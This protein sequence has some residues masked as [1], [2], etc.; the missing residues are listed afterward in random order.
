[1]E[2]SREMGLEH[3]LMVVERFLGFWKAW[4]LK[5]ATETWV[6]GNRSFLHKK[7]LVVKPFGSTGEGRI[8]EKSS[9]RNNAHTAFAGYA[10][11]GF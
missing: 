4:A 5:L 10:K 2:N 1:V 7:Y 3:G 11:I 9:F 6:N 8:V